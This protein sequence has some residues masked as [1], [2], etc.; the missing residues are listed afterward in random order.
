[1]TII[2]DLILGGGNTSQVP[3]DQY[4]G[5]LLIENIWGLT[6]KLVGNMIQIKNRNA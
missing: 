2:H 4:D 3:I 5:M 1:V 6:L